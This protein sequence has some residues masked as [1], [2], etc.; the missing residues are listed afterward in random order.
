MPVAWE[1]AGGYFGPDN[2]GIWRLSI[3]VELGEAGRAQE[4]ARHPNPSVREAIA[5]LMRWTQR[6][7]VGRD[8][9][10]MAYRMGIGVG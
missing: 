3:A 2:V 8:L 9:R 4:V 5:D 6:D 1:V 7:A 10:G